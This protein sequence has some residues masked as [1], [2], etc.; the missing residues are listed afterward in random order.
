MK[1]I[2]KETVMDFS[3]FTI[4]GG[5]IFALVWGFAVIGLIDGLG[6]LVKRLKICMGVK[7]IVHIPIFLSPRGNPSRT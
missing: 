5:L 1:N 2:I 4:F 7:K 3:I 6:P